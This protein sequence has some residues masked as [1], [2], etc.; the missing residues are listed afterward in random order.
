MKRPFLLA[1][2]G[3]CASTDFIQ[4]TKLEDTPENRE[5]VRVIER[6]RRALERRDV[7]ALL[8][9]AHPWYFEDS[10]TAKGDDDYG[11]DGLK[12]VLATRLADVQSVRYGIQ[13]KK[14]SFSGNRARV[15]V[16]IDAS[17]QHVAEGREKW[18]R[19]TDD[20]EIELIKDDKGWR[21]LAGM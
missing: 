7:A 15:Q 12:K 3:A 16:F 11:Y 1:W 20:N 6:Y 13:Y 14:V 21:F 18:Q 19:K 10:G 17:F 8:S 9:M 2:L 4:G 5:M